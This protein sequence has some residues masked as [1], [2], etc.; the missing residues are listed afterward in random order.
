MSKRVRSS[1][2][3]RDSY[4]PPSSSTSQNPPARQALRTTKITEKLVLF[5]DNLVDKIIT[6]DGTHSRAERL[7][8]EGRQQI[9]RVTSYCVCE[10]IQ[11]NI[12]KNFVQNSHGVQKSKKFDECLYFSYGL[13]RKEMLF[14]NSTTPRRSKGDTNYDTMGEDSQGSHPEGFPDWMSRGDVFIFDYGVVVLWNF[15]D[16]E[17]SNFLSH[18][19]Q[20]QQG[21]LKQDG[22]FM[23]I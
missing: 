20:F 9:P 4:P 10:V 15:T 8:K 12:L 21:T 19:L 17:E 23:L 5:P 7:N 3:R 14:G 16:Q 2:R 22:I 11:L 13:D 18:M 6:D 1:S